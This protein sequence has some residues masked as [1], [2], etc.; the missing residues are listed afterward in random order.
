MHRIGSPVLAVLPLPHE[1]S[2]MADDFVRALFEEPETRPAI[3]LG[4][5]VAVLRQRL[6]ADRTLLAALDEAS[7][8]MDREEEPYAG[9]LRALLGAGPLAALRGHLGSSNLVLWPVKLGLR[10]VLGRTFGVVAYRL[11]DLETGELVYQHS[12]SLNVDATGTQAKALLTL[13]LVGR[14]RSGYDERF[15]ARR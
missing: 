11:Y 2:D 12:E 9:D 10:E 14:A 3:R 8:R 7:R 5:P 6:A 13:H 4:V 15:L 1:R